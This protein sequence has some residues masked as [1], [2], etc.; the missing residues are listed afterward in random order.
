MPINPEEEHC[1]GTR[2]DHAK[3][4]RLTGLERQRCI[5]IEA[6]RLGRSG[7]LSAFNWREIGRLVTV[8]EVDERGVGHGFGTTWILNGDEIFEEHIMLLVIPITED[9]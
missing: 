5:F 9:D 8:H 2:I 1:E 3:P 6:D 7:G 4:V